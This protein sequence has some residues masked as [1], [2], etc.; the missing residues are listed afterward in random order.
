MIIYSVTVKIEHSIEKDWVKWMREVHI[1]DVMKTGL[2]KEYRMSKVMVQ[3][4]DGVNYSIQYLCPSE[5]Q[6]NTYLNEHA[7]GL[8][9]KHTARYKDKFVAFR[10]LLE[11]IDHS[12]I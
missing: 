10:T 4:P 3:D 1:A 5:A 8:Q 7:K 2:F 12:G 11:V 9:E 6:L